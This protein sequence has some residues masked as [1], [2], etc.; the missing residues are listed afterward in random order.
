[1]TDRLTAAQAALNA[2]RADEAI[3]HLVAAVGDDPARPASVYRILAAQLYGARRY[4]EGE[5]FAAKG[6]ER[7]PRDYELLNTRGVLLRKLKREADAAR[8]LEQAVKLDSKRLAAQQN[9]GNVLLDLNQGQRAEAVFSK[10]VRL[11]PRNAEFQ[12]QL[13]RALLKQGKAEPGISRFRQATLVRRDY[14]DAWLDLV[15]TLTEEFRLPEAL[16]ALDK[17]ITANPGEQRLLEAKAMVL[18]RAGDGAGA[19]AFLT[20]LLPANPNAAWLHYQLGL[21]IAERDR[22]RGNISLQKA[23][24]LDPQKMEYAIAYIESL[25]R[26]RTG[27]EGDNIERAYRRALPLLDRPL[28]FSETTTKVLT[29]V[30]IRVCDYDALE[31]VGDFRTLGRGWAQSGRHTA[32]LKQIAQVKDDADRLELMEQHRIWGRQIEAAAARRTIKRP[33]PRP[34]GGKIR[35]GFMSSDLRQHPVGYFAMPLFEHLDNDRFEVFVYSYYTGEE[36]DAQRYITQRIAGYRWWPDIGIGQAAERIAADQLDLLIDLGGTTHM[37]KLE[38]M[39][40]K[41]ARLQASWL[42]YPHSAGL[43]N[44]DYFICDAHN[45]PT[46]PDLLLEKPLFMPKTWIALGARFF[47][48]LVP[49][50]E[51]P[52]LKNGFITYGTANNPHKYTRDMLRAWARVVAATP[53]SRFAFIRPEG[54]GATFRSNIAK[55]FA[56]EGVSEDRLVFHAVRGAHLPFYN[57][58]DITLDTFPLTGGTTTT[59]ALWMGV[60]VVSLVGPAFYERLSQSILINSGAPELA[61]NDPD[62]FAKIAIDLANDR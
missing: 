35:L 48:N 52:E 10:L 6:L 17:A 5:T 22:A 31:K 30:F 13:G 27:D 11:E 61:T 2:G 18:R 26:T 14:I 24:D 45:L 38:V 41:P 37:N 25:E 40:Y 47:D 51:P 39:A 49:I 23:V 20:S 60:P 50:A 9:L 57:E 16:E 19:E 15:G 53:N 55:E 33:P 4:A 21:I 46:R 28:E 56:A 29:E 44:I 34:P 7:Y 3:Q 54:G 59:E 42:G 8:V 32:L 1:M 12:R 43:S 58:V 36:D 62:E